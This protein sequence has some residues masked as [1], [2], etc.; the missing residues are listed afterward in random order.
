MRMLAVA[1]V[2][3]L[4]FLPA[5]GCGN[6]GDEGGGCLGECVGCSLAF[7]ATPCCD[8]LECLGG[9]Q[10]GGLQCARFDQICP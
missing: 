8:G 1:I 2:L 10:S 5:L 9:H 3:V 6:G 7:D 4:V